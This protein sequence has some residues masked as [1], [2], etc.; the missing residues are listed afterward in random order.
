MKTMRVT[1]LLLTILLLFVVVF[2]SFADE[3]LFGYV[4]GAETIP[5]G[6]TQVYQWLTERNGKSDGTY[7]GRD[8]RTEIEY[9]LSNRLQSSFYINAS[10]H[11]ISNAHSNSEEHSE[12]LSSDFPN[13]STSLE[14]NGF[15][16]ALKYIL[17]SPYKPNKLGGVGLALYV[18]PGYSTVHKVTGEKMHEY[19]VETRFI[20]QKNFLEDRMVFAFNVNSEFEK[21]KMRGESEWEDE[22]ALEF[23]SGLT[24]LFRPNWYFGFESRYHSEYPGLMG[25]NKFLLSPNYGPREHWAVFLGPVVHYA[26]KKWWITAT[27]LPQ[28]RGG[29]DGGS[30]HGSKHLG[31][32]EINEVRLKVSYVL[33]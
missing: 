30:Q 19:S 24:Y 20:I 13:K 17:L 12:G 18:E 15:S 31:E 6:Q 32:H 7:V 9:G 21:R 4:Q 5:K 23:T 16:N 3:Q 26:A 33:N 1:R 28:I 11:D 8:Y 25:R 29:L 22:V 14:F 27:W 2:D 10:G